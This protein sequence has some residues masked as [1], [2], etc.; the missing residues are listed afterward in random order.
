MY[1]GLEPLLL[2]RIWNGGAAVDMSGGIVISV[3]AVEVIAGNVFLSMDVGLW[4]GFG[5]I[6][7]FCM[8][9]VNFGNGRLVA[10]AA[11]VGK[12]FCREIVVDDVS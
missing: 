9:Y 2:L 10:A 7:D 3:V 8:N 12:V 6:G 5:V 4:F 11:I 1:F